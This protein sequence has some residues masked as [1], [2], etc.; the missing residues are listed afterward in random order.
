MAYKVYKKNMS[1]QDFSEALNDAGI[2]LDD[3]VKLTGRHRAQAHRYLTGEDESGPT[4]AEIVIVEF[5]ADNPG[6]VQPMLEI[7][8]EWTDAE[9][10]NSVPRTEARRAKFDNN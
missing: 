3:F 1:P 9:R 4:L 6:L 10:E 5:L 7:A 8:A 2:T